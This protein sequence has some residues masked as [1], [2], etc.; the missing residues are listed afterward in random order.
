[1]KKII[2]IMLAFI[3]LLTSCNSVSNLVP[4]VLASDTQKIVN[5]VEANSDDVFAEIQS[6]IDMVTDLKAKVQQTQIDGKPL[7]LDDVIRDLQKVTQSYESLA[8]DHQGIKAGLLKKIT[9][10]EDMQ[11]DV[12]KQIQSLQQKKTDYQKQLKSI[13]DPDPAIVATRQ[14][15][16]TQAITYV[17]D[18]IALWQS[19]S[20]IQTNIIAETDNVQKTID[21]FLNAI[22]SSAIVF[23]EGLNLLSLQ[24]DLNDAMS[25]FT[26]DLPTMEQLTSDMQA[27]WNNLDYLVEALTNV[28]SMEVTK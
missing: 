21:S 9:R 7:S 20:A 12:S 4:K 6:N 16:L 28:G 18:Q 17:D 24:R 14:N 23:R 13:N 19:F 27:S 15:A 2:I 8:N 26:Q 5:Q 25:L 1:M 22:D 3:L 11:S 10:L